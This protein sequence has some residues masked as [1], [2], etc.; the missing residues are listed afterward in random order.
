MDES[1]NNRLKNFDIESDTNAL[2]HIRKVYREL[3][4]LP[5]RTI[6]SL[7]P[8]GPD[9]ANVVSRSSEISGRK[10]QNASTNFNQGMWLARISNYSSRNSNH[11]INIIELGTCVG[12]ST[13]YL[14]AGVAKTGSAHIITFEGSP[15]LAD[16]AKSHITNFLN[17]NSIKN[18]TFEIIVGSID[19]KLYEALENLDSLDLSFID[20]NHLEQATLEYHAAIG[21]KTSDHGIIVHD[22]IN[23]GAG[24]KRAW[25]SICRQENTHQ[26][27]EFHLGGK[28]SRG[29]IFR[30]QPGSSTI[31]TIHM[32]G[33]IERLARK[34]KASLT[35]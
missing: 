23:W 21:S 33:V 5:I 22:D 30:S 29:V 6:T 17:S 20:G 14:M 34:I 19:E 25:K 13:M 12:I 15:E 31:S 1:L 28:P 9:D 4:K 16:L 7:G 10:L 18:I 2:E 24:M 27:L 35:K 8:E 11:P 3:P 32:D 26:I